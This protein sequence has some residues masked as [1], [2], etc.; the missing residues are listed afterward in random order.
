VP[1]HYAKLTRAVVEIGTQLRRL[2]D[3][4]TTPVGTCD[5]S[6]AEG[7]AGPLG[8]CIL[9]FEHD[10][11]VHQDADGRRWSTAV[12]DAP[13]TTPYDDPRC[14]CGDPIVLSGD[15]ARWIHG[16]GAGT[17]ALDAHTVRPVPAADH[18]PYLLRVLADRAA[19]GA[20]SLPGEGE[21]LRRRVEQAIDRGDQLRAQRD[22]VEELLRVAHETSNRSEAERARAVQRAERAEEQRDQLRVTLD[23]VLR[24]F[25]RKGH[26]G[27]PCLESGWV[28]EDTVARW[29][30]VLHP[31]AAEEQSSQR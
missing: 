8:P 15:P 25:V 6:L 13:T 26:P 18:A 31:P 12:S 22:Q 7:I 28:H 21:A 29:R 9:R 30:A 2:A 10:G 1:D 5:T 19:R 20:L 14:V 24:H 16:P 4:N 27:A 23:E 11:P 3:A 17:P